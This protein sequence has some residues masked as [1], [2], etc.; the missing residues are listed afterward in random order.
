MQYDWK[1][2]K[3]SYKYIKKYFTSCTYKTGIAIVTNMKK[4]IFYSIV[5]GWY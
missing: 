4:N 1:L 5:G 2:L 3:P